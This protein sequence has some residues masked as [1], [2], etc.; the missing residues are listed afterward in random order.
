M[1]A[2]RLR[3]STASRNAT[4]VFLVHGRDTVGRELVARL[5]ERVCDNTEIVV[6]DEQAGGARTIIEKFEA[7]AGRSRF[8][9]VLITGDDRGA[10]LG[11]K[12]RPRARQNVIFE[13][14]WF[15][16]TAGRDAV[17][18]LYED[19]IDLPSD[20]AG[21]SWIP[22]RS[23]GRWRLPLMRELAQAGVSV[24]VRRAP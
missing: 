7:A 11:Q 6:L 1:L 18:V 2:G 17:F 15:M 22:F 3:R 20:V 19:D 13:L 21:V 10:L 9:V 12:P 23:D 5:L 4:T 24:D 16:G 8:A 14:G